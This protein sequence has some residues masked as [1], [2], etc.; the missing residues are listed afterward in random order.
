MIGKLDGNWV[1]TK[2]IGEGCSHASEMLLGS[3]AS[4]QGHAS[5]R[6]RCG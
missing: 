4:N 6:C 2:Y 5:G 3:A 1:R